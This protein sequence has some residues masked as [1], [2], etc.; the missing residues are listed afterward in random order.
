MF[1]QSAWRCKKISQLLGYD[2]LSSA[3]WESKSYLYD[4]FLNDH[5]IDI[6]NMHF[7][8]WWKG[9]LFDREIFFSELKKSLIYCVV[10][11]LKT[12]KDQNH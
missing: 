8:S 7:T 11:L 2:C 6:E 3:G 5:G 10:D 9:M 12:E 1:K 4:H